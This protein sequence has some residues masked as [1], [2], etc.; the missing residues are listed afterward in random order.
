MTD[1]QSGY[2]FG[3][4]NAFAGVGTPQMYGINGDNGIAVVVELGDAKASI[5]GFTSEQAVVEA[6]AI[7]QRSCSIGELV[8]DGAEFDLAVAILSLFASKSYVLQDEPQ[9]DGA[10]AIAEQNYLDA[11]IEAWQ[12]E[13]AGVSF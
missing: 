2:Q 8:E 12:F 9:D 5:L 10:D 6:I 3:V 11:D 4:L 1:T 13:K 7:A